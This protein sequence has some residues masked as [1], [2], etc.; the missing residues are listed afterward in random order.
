MDDFGNVS[1]DPYCTGKPPLAIDIILNLDALGIVLYAVLTVMAF[2]SVLVYMEEAVYIYKKIPG[3]KKTAIMWVNGAAPL[4]GT[5]ACLGMWIPRS[6]MFTDFTAATYFAIVIH[7][8]LVM[9]IE[10]CGGDEGFLKL[11]GKNRL[12][13]STGPCCCCCLCLPYVGIS[14]RT[15]FLLKAGTFQFAFFRMVFTI[16]SILLWTNDN[17]DTAN[18]S[19]TSAAIWINP[20]VG[21]LTII[22]LWPVAMM[23][24]QTRGLLSSKK[25]IPK[26]V[27]YQLVLILSQ[28]QSAII[29]ILAMGGNIACAPPFSS[30]ARG[31]FMNQQLLIM[32]MF[33]VTLVSRIF[34]RRRYEELD[35]VDEHEEDN[36][37][38]AKI[39]L[40][41]DGAQWA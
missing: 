1:I 13:I 16:L 29:N 35:A 28:L 30:Q 22:S 37:D 9:M 6:T 18:L 25:I 11:C 39:Q 7:M 27:L 31:S 15:L 20:F 26:F 32:E 41:E 21:I 12:K 5:T 17:F 3:P 40:K 38:N 34:Y 2:I 23:F 24:N 19:I 14:R 10:E 8:F 36:K 33:I 4:I